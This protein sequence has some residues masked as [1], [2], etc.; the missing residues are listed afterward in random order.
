MAAEPSDDFFDEPYANRMEK[1]PKKFSHGNQEGY[2]EDGVLRRRNGE[3]MSLSPKQIRTRARRRAARK[4][5]PKMFAAELVAYGY[6]PL[7]EWDMEELAAGKPKDANGHLRP[8]PG[9]KWL[10]RDIQERSLEI[11]K[12][13][14]RGEMREHTVAAVKTLRK[15]MDSE[16]EDER[17]KPIVPASAKIDVAKFLV[18]HL[19]G[20][21]T[22]PV[23][24]DVSVKLQG[25]LASVLVQP[26]QLTGAYVPSS[27]HRPVEGADVV[28]AEIVDEEEDD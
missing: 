2:D 16:E 17:G 20:K 11:F 24:A 3:E 5:Q 9:P 14:I 15:L 7:E 26:D 28:D 8:G 21:P 1:R 4:H 18:E 19:I 12:D 27:S 22:Q 25:I 6:K 10:T 13:R 23:Q